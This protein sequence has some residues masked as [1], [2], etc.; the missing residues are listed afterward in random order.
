MLEGL[1]ILHQINII[2]GDIN[3]FNIMWSNYYKKYVFIDFGISLFI[4]ENIGQKSL[5]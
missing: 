4:R 1:S 2:H 3:R 5:I